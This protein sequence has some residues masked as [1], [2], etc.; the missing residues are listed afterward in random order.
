MRL[1]KITKKLVWLPVIAGLLLCGTAYRILAA[2]G[3]KGTATSTSN[4]LRQPLANTSGLVAWYPL[5][6]DTKDYSGNHYDATA[7]GFTYDGTSNGWTGGKFGKALLFHSSDQAV[8]GP[9]FALPNAVSASAWVKVNSYGNPPYIN[10]VGKAQGGGNCTSD[11]FNLVLYG[12]ADFVVCNPDGSN[13]QQVVQDGGNFFATGSWHLIVGT[14]DGATG[15]LKIYTDGSLK[16]TTSTGYTQVVQRNQRFLIGANGYSNSDSVAI[17]DVR[18]YNRALSQ[19]EIANLSTGSPSSNCD[20]TCKIWL[21]FDDNSGTVATDS[22]GKYPGTLNGSASW[23]TGNYS[24]AVLLN[25]STGYVSVPDLGMASGTLD[26][27]INPASVA[28]DQRLFAQASGSSAQAGQIT[29]NQSSGENGSL[30]TWDGSA[31]Q[32]LTPDGTVKAGQWNQIVV[33]NNG[34]TA[35][36]YVNGVQQLTA[37]SNFAFS[38]VPSVIGGKFLGTAGGTFNGSVDDFRIYSRFLAPE[39]VADQWRQGN[40]RGFW[41]L[42]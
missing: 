39:E 11:V 23:T 21:K 33:A 7:S 24:S 35:T 14:F 3:A 6:G 17:D 1:P 9:S 20:Q 15:L 16:A 29:L 12:G 37:A 30:W 8:A 27:W 38:G 31:W 41:L 18:V 2:G 5:D 22:V 13:T 40:I 26:M 10:I 28:G 34:G 25:G 19:S 4:N 32:R 42:L 36:A